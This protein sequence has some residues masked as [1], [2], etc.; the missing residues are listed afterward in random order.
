MKK[1]VYQFALYV[2]AIATLSHAGII[3]SYSIQNAVASGFGGWNHTFNG[4]IVETGTVSFMDIAGITAEYTNGTGT[5]NDGIIGSTDQTTQLFFKEGAVSPVITLNLD[6]YY[7]IEDLTL[8]NSEMFY[9]N[10]VGTISSVDVT[11]NGFSGTFLTTTDMGAK[12]EFVNL[13]GSA[14][15][16]SEQPANQIILSGFVSET[17]IQFEN[18]F[19]FSEIAVTATSASVPE[20]SVVPLLALGFLGLL[21]ISLQQHRRLAR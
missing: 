9:S 7:F 16:L 15:A 8:L 20:A 1:I 19:A 5:L 11:I 12:S 10:I 17:G 21:V 18:L 6:N 2:L 13:A 14:Y 3:S 4:E